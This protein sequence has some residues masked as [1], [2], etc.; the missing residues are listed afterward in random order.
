M[1]VPITLTIFCQ[2]KATCTEVSLGQDQ[3]HPEV[4]IPKKVM[5]K[6]ESKVF[7]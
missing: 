4:G 2:A 6:I 5:A 7:D 1:L 3:F